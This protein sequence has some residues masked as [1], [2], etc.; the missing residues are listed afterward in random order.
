ML[1]S[2]EQIVRN[3]QNYVLDTDTECGCSIIAL[4][5]IIVAYF[6]I[7]ELRQRKKK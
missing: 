3:A 4:L 1:L 2:A 5:L 6:V 7:K